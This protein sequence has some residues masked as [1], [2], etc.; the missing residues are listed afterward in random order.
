MEGFKYVD[1]FAT[2]GIEYIAAVIFLIVLVY[3]WRS[4]NKTKLTTKQVPVNT[5][6]RISLVDWFQMANDYYY[7]QGHSWLAPETANTARVGIDDFTQKMLG[8][9][10]G[11][12]LP[13]VGTMVQQGQPGIK[14]NVDGK[15]VDI[16]SPVSG[17]VI[18]VNENFKH[19]TDLLNKDP[20][21]Q[22]WLFRVKS[23]NLMSNMRNLLHGNVAKAWIQDTVDRLSR[24]ITD[25]Y[26]VVMQDGGVISN[27]FIKELEPDNWEQV[28]AEFF[29]TKDI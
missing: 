4:L 25:H 2:K 26:G 28:A 24:R 1:I 11:L 17:E 22:G 9:P 7:H 15:N 10:S 21:D 12:D 14:I 23:N 6:N 8:K 3:F 29:L 27:G 19:N 5:G 18:E 20:Y 16:L 13:E